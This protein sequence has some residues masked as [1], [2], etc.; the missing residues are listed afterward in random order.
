M[1]M[2]IVQIMLDSHSFNVNVNKAE[3][4]T[5]RTPISLKIHAKTAK[6]IIK[7]PLLLQKK[8]F[9]WG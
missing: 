1:V 5:F 8:I 3:G 7:K 4:K 9:I 2:C 6:K